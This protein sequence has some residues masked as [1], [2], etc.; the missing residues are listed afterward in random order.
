V[1]NEAFGIYFNGYVIWKEEIPSRLLT[2]FKEEA[3]QS[4]E[5][6]RDEDFIW[7]QERF[8][9][10]A[11]LNEGGQIPKKDEDGIRIGRHID[12]DLWDFLQKNHNEKWDAIE[13]RVK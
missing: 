12:I 7:M 10:N 3:F 11:W 9:W 13:A 6:M 8:D 5:T 2:F 1:K 4:S